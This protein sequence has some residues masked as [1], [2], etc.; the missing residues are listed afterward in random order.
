MENCWARRLIQGAAGKGVEDPAAGDYREVRNKDVMGGAQEIDAHST[1]HP[2]SF[3]SAVAP[4]MASCC[5]PHHWLP[6]A[7]GSQAVPCHWHAEQG[8]AVLPDD[9]EGVGTKFP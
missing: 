5:I 2:V 1:E 6:A 4:R 3:S 8:V 9:G 7:V